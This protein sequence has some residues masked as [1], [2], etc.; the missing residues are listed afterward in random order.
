MIPIVIR[1]VINIVLFFLWF[2]EVKKYVTERHKIMK[3][4]RMELLE[5]EVS[6]K[7]KTQGSY[8]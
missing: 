8:T 3:L 7:K 1:G 6:I 4:V 2:L 5:V